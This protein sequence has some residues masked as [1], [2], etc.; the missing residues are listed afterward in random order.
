MMQEL[1]GL[2]ATAEIQALSEHY[3][4]VP[5]IALTANVS[6]YDKQ[7]YLASGMT[8]FKPKPVDPAYLIEVIAKY[9]PQ[10]SGIGGDGSRDNTP[11]KPMDPVEQTGSGMSAYG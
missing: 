7:H 6:E 2:S 4:A 11:N 5:I 1:D 8:D 3:K 9:I 10:E